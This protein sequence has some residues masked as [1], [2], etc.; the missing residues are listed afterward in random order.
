MATTFKVKESPKSEQLLLKERK[1]SAHNYTPMPIV[2]HEAHGVEITDVDGNKFLDFGASYGTTNQGHSH[3]KIVEAV[4]EQSKTLALPSRAFTH[5]LFGEFCELLCTKWGFDK[6][7]PL[8]GGGEAIEF[9]IKLCRSWGYV[10]K[11]IAPNEAKVLMCANNYHGR[12]IG[13][14]SGSTNPSARKNYGPF[15]PNVGPSYGEDKILRFNNLDDLK[16]A[17]ELEGDKIAGIIIETVQGEGGINI[18]DPDYYDN[19]RKLCDE[20]KV[21][22]VADEIQVGNFRTGKKIWAYENLSNSKP[23]VLVTAKS[24]TGGLYPVSVV[25][26]SAEIMDT[27]EPNSHGGTFTGSPIGCAAVIAA[28]NVLYDEKMG[29]RA[30]SIGPVMIGGLKELMSKYDMIKEVRGVGLLSAF[31]VDETKIGE[32][33]T[34]WHVC[35]FLRAKGIACKM[36]RN[37]TVRWCPPLVI[38]EE[39]IKFALECLEDCCKNLPTMDANEIPDVERFHFLNH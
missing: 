35:M 20:Y 3:P 4:I 34:A 39:Q 23:D 22:W 33:K 9:A 13:V 21:L 29:D 18:P 37:G 2:Y 5:D 7:L 27:I 10:T 19:V 17:F 32:G 14:T 1:F 16:E 26:S 12:H 36:V 11:N 15:V 25:L 8:N 30:D 31:D 24:I 6:V 38:T 28:V